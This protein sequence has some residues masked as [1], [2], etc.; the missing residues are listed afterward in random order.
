MSS[1]IDVQDSKELSYCIDCIIWSS[2]QSPRR[3][4]CVALW[5]SL[6]YDIGRVVSLM[7][8]LA[9]V[10]LHFVSFGVPCWLQPGP[11]L[12]TLEVIGRG[13][14]HCMLLGPCKKQVLF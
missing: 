8:V 10:L 3:R 14:L 12:G 11:L 5:L 2:C 9:C 1:Y 13:N 6:L 7:T 4:T